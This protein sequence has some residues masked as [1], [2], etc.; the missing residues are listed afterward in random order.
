MNK[1]QTM[2]NNEEIERGRNKTDNKYFHQSTRPL[3]TAVPTGFIDANELFL[4][5]ILT[6]FLLK[7][8]V[9]ERA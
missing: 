7:M 1:L 4:L 5:Y 2:R 9:Q 8:L 3:R 6:R